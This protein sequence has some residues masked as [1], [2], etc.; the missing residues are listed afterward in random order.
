[1]GHITTALATTHAPQL[2]IRPKESED[3]EEVERTHAAM[4]E[5]GRQ[6]D[7]S[8]AETIV[9]F[10][11]DHAENFLDQAVAPFTVFTGNEVEAAFGPH[12]PR[13]RVDRELAEWILHESIEAGNDLAYSQRVV[14]DHSFITPLRFVH[15]SNRLPIVPIIVNVY[16]APQPTPAR[17][18]QFG[19]MLRDVLLRGP[20][21]VALLASGGMSHYPGTTQYAHPDFEFDRK[22]L[23]QLEGG[24][25]GV[26]RRMSSK[27]LDEVGNIELRTWMVLMGVI[28]EQTPATVVH[29]EPCWHHGHGMLYFNLDRSLVRTA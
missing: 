20:R 4:G 16:L 8:D 13:Y 17:C 26:M 19:E 11:I 14:L 9:M 25:G 10:A 18:F 3:R 28:G 7:A 22:L 15:P 23:K 27:Y 6:L 1:M 2:L 5:L 21:R 12:R 24:E 29:Y